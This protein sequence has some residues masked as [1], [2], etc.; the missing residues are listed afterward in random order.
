HPL[1]TPAVL[2]FVKSLNHDSLLVRKVHIHIH[3]HIHIHLNIHI[4]HTHKHTHIHILTHTHTH[5][6]VLILFLHSAA[7]TA[8]HYSC[9]GLVPVSLPFSLSLCVCGLGSLPADRSQ[10]CCSFLY[11][12]SSHLSLLT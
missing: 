4:T 1:P 8:L 6:H 5:T 9:H 7:L 12:H 3:I 10:P 11:V 2:F